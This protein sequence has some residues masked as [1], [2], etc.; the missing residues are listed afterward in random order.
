MNEKNEI[1]KVDLKVIKK[2]KKE[3]E[4]KETNAIKSKKYNDVKSKVKENLNT[5]KNS[6][7]LDDLIIRV[8]NEIKQIESDKKRNKL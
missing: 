6:N 5:F 7:N 8:E 2:T 1:N 3:D 4:H